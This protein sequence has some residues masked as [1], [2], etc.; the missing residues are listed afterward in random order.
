MNDGVT[1]TPTAEMP[2]KCHTQMSP[3][4]SIERTS[5]VNAAKVSASRRTAQIRSR[6]AGTTATEVLREENVAKGHGVPADQ[7]AETQGAR[8]HHVGYRRYRPFERDTDSNASHHP[9]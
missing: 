3:L 4:T 9:V 7:F 6:P 5:G 8:R 1:D 2:R